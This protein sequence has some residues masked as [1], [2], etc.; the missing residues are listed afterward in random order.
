M[1][2]LQVNCVYNKGSTGKIVFDIHKGLQEQGIES[3]VC[4]GRGQKVCEKNVYKT[5]SELY[6]KINNLFSRITGLMYGGCFFSTNKLIK[7]IKKEKPDIVHLHCLNGY[8]VNIYRLITWL[9]KNNFRTVLTLHAEFMHTANCGHAFDCDKWKTGCGGCP[10]LKKETKSLFFD[11]TAKSW[12]KMKQSFEG[13]ENLQIIGVSNWIS[14]RAKMSPIFNRA[15]I[16]TIYNGIH[17]GLFSYSQKEEK[18]CNVAN[19]YGIDITKKVV[20]HVTPSFAG[21]IKGGKYFLDLAKK[22][23]DSFQC[24]VVGVDRNIE[25]DIVSIPFISN[26]QELAAIYSIASVLVITSKSDNYPTVCLEAN[27]C[28][29]PVVGFDVGGVKETIYDGMGKTVTFG[30]MISL[31]NAVVE[32]S[33]EKSNIR[34]SQI[35]ACRESRDCERMIKEYKKLFIDMIERDGCKS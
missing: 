9:K 30:D 32:Y 21:E 7:I 14:E 1:K 2:V 8:F 29:T 31:Q 18:L 13:F 27:C 35:V 23:D 3:V 26:Q 28:G 10:R 33:Y 34:E 6:S 20:L 16:E 22:L 17:V 25:N 15:K 11:R 12:S 19:K 24:V 5:C 4:Y